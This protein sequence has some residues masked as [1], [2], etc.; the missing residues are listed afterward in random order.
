MA[1]KLKEMKI[2]FNGKTVSIRVDMHKESWYIT[3][4]VGGK[5]LLA[6]TLSRPNYDA[7]KKVFAR[8]KGNYVRIV[9]EAGPGG[10][11]L[12]DRLTAHGI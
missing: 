3:A 1:S 4:L 2:N 7:F 6:L 12:Y 11:D 8:F 9:Y 5:I 10:F